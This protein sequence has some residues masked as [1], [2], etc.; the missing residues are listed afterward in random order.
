MRS[1]LQARMG[2]IGALF[3]SPQSNH[4]VHAWA[5]ACDGYSVLFA[6]RMTITDSI[7]RT[8]A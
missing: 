6:Q 4:R 5:E 7:G 8:V 3:L 2:Y 1:T